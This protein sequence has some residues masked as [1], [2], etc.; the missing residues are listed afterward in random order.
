MGFKDFYR[1]KLN[2]A[3]HIPIE[4]FIDFEAEK[5]KVVEKLV[6]LIQ[7]VESFQVEEVVEQLLKY[8]KNFPLYVR[9]ELK[10]MEELQPEKYNEVIKIIP[11]ELQ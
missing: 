6:K 7:S 1:K 11:E 4:I 10:V 9:N 3:P 2:E 8:N 5:S